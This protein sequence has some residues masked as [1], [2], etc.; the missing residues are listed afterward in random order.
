[1]AS[2]SG[3]KAIRSAFAN[4]NFRLYTTGNVCSHMGTWVQRTAVGWLTWELTHSALWL[5]MI[6][7]ADLLPTVFLAPLAGAF[8]DRVERIQAIKVTQTMAMIQAAA[9]AALT[10]S[11]LITAEI[12]LGLTFL[13]GIVNAI[14]QPLR[15]ATIPSLVERKDMA[16]AIGINSLSF[17]GSRVVAP[18]IAGVLIHVSGTAPCFALNAVSFTAFLVAL[19]KL[20]K[21]TDRPTVPKPLGNIPVEIMEGFLY[22][23]R[24]VG[25]A[26]MIVMTT[27]TAVLGLAFRE[28]L[29]GFAD[30]VFHYGAYGFSML[31][32]SMGA[33]AVIAGM[34]MASRGSL[35]GL[36]MVVIRGVFVLGVSVLAFTVAPSIWIGMA[37]IACSGYAA[38]TCSVGQ[39]TLLQSSTSTSMRGRMMSLYGMIARGGPSLGALAMGALNGWFGLR[40]PVLGGAAM[41]LLLWLWVFQRRHRMAEALE[42]VPE[43][44]ATET[45]VA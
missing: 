15:M 33:G 22:C 20:G 1:M 17:N 4:R 34:M 14:N 36:T 28:L 39:Q 19:F 7:M 23:M 5:G 35:E 8:A 30:E 43:E 29:P 21:V 13:L 38:V 31:L 44:I 37:C 26:P 18:T 41:C 6:S 42:N 24:H 3:F 11:G 45:A 40:W 16:A 25:I 27:F 32:S 10:W 12:L 2:Q 9:L